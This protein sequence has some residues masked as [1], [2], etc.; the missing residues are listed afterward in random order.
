MADGQLA[1]GLRHTLLDVKERGLQMRVV[2][3][4]SLIGPLV[5][6]VPKV[7]SYSSNFMSRAAGNV[8]SVKTEKARRAQQQYLA[9]HN[10]C[11]FAQ[12]QYSIRSKKMGA[13]WSMSSNDR[14]RRAERG[15]WIKHE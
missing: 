9:K 4:T 12:S 15:G 6:T 14:H 1:V 13:E 5:V 3:P 7:H 8:S 11:V 2:F 10:R